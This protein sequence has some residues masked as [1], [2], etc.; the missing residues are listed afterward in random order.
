[1]QDTLRTLKSGD[2]GPQTSR[3]RLWKNLSRPEEKGSM[4]DKGLKPEF[5][6]TPSAQ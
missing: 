6:K 3:E 1:V 2:T 5:K 4:E